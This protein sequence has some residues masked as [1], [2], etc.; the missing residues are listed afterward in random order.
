[1]MPLFSVGADGRPDVS[2]DDPYDPR[3]VL[4]HFI[5]SEIYL[6]LDNAD[7]FLQAVAD[8][9]RGDKDTW[10]WSGNSFSLELVKEGCTITDQWTEPDDPYPGMVH[11]TVQEFGDVIAAWR[12][13]VVSQGLGLRTLT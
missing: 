4:A 12:E 3:H 11:L 8:I 10:C 6:F 2:W 9:K 13:F 1:M 7:V 5:G